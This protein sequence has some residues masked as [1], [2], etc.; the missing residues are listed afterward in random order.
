[1]TAFLMTTMSYSIH[2]ENESPVFGKGATTVSIDDEAAGAFIVIKQDIPH[3]S[4]GIALE[5]DELELVL[6][7]ARKLLS[8]MPK[9]DA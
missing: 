6:V 3:E 2:P 5:I 9:E 7:A 4:G 1:M 8:G